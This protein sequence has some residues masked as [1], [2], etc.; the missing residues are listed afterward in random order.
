MNNFETDRI[1][2]TKAAKA[3]NYI[4]SDRGGVVENTHLVH[5]TV[6]DATG[7][8]LFT[9]GDPSR[10]TLVRSAAKP[11]QTL[12]LLEIP[13]FD[14]F[15][16]DD[17][18]IAL[19]CSSH[20]SEKRHIQRARNM[21]VKAKATEEDLRCGGHPA[22]SD[23]VNRAWIKADYAPTGICNNC[24]AKHAGM[25]AGAKALGN[26]EGYHRPDHPVQQRVM[27]TIEELAQLGADGVKWGIDGCNLP[28]PAMPLRTIGHLYALLANAADAH[29]EPEATPRTRHLGT[30]F[31]NMW[32]YPGLIGGDGRFCTELML[33]YGGTLV[34]KLGADGCY[35][36]GI[37][38]SEQTRRLGAEG[39]IGISVKVEDG[40]ISIL[41]AA[42]MEILEQLDIGTPETRQMLESFR[43]VKRLNTAGVVIGNVLCAF[44]MRPESEAASCA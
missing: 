2:M 5:A 43:K 34:G 36:V 41:Y 42:V 20:S 6:S 4:V 35:G 22:L 33:A 25:L 10:M 19:M 27:G 32:K 8:L 18:D 13:G 39:A 31:N 3:C 9:T 24:S 7:K 23:A 40:D 21:L 17:A 14:Q 11:F 1:K 15:G 28:A 37:R 12:A 29:D 44:N 16:F 30:I 38:P 26:T